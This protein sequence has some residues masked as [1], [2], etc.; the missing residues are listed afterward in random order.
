MKKIAPC[1]SLHVNQKNGDF[2][3]TNLAIDRQFGFLVGWGPL[4]HVSRRQMKEEGLRIVLSNLEGFQD[5]DA[6]IGYELNGD[7]VRQRKFEKLHTSI[8]LT[9]YDQSSLELLPMRRT[10]RGGG[11]GD[12][13][14]LITLTFPCSNEEFYK[15]IELAETRAL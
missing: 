2:A 10:R 11:T 6:T 5:R 12:K 7:V 8:S 4:V 9:L 14:D 3:I 15:A 1:L 13:E